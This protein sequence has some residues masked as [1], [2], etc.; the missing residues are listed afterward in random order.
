MHHKRLVC[1]CGK[2][3]LQ[4][5]CPGPHK[6][7]VSPNPCS[8]APRDLMENQPLSIPCPA[9]G[10]GENQRLEAVAAECHK[11][12]SGWTE[13]LLGKMKPSS[14]D[15]EAGLF[16]DDIW[17]ERWMRQVHTEYK[18]LTEEEKESDRREARKILEALRRVG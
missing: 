6:D 17:R 10:L 11:Q 4:C 3:L 5:R 7:E 16:L 18:D 2:V 1:R 15:D 14:F 13:Y 8:C 12:W 9:E